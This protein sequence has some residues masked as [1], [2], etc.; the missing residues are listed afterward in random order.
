MV[1]K[2]DSLPVMIV[3]STLLD[4]YD[5]FVYTDKEGGGYR[6]QEIC[7]NTTIFIRLE[8]DAAG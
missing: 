8:A 3:G 4:T 6:D 2:L 7:P 5:I 1:S